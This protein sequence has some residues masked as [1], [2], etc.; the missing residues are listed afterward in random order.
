M[1]L[2]DRHCGWTVACAV[3]T[4]TCHESMNSLSNVNST[5]SV[6][7]Q[8]ADGRRTGADSSA[9]Q[10][11]VSFQRSMRAC[12]RTPCNV[13]LAACRL[14]LMQS[15][16]ARSSRHAI[17]SGGSAVPPSPWVVVFAWR[18]QRLAAS[19]SSNYSLCFSLSFPCSFGFS[20][21]RNPQAASLILLPWQR[22]S[23]TSS[24]AAR[25]RAH[26]HTHTREGTHSSASLDIKATLTLLLK[27]CFCS[28]LLTIRLHYMPHMPYIFG[29][30]C[31][32]DYISWHTYIYI[33]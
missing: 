5:S 11:S 4:C 6:D 23:L 3:D 22:R 30:L 25:A 16:P 26:T 18:L 9:N 2:I 7:D 24:R 12:Q 29:S 14:Q 33:V 32:H 19:I 27:I 21:C 13:T 1:L 31:I 15:S 17:A 20:L 8:P 10:P 28:G